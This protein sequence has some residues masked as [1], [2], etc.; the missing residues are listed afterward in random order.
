M[1]SPNRTKHTRQRVC[2]HLNMGSV[3]ML[4]DKNMVNG[5]DVN[6]TVE[7]QTQCQPC[8]IAKQHVKS[9]PQESHTDIAEIGDL[10]V[11][12]LWGP[13][14]THGIGRESYFIPF[15]DGKSRCTMIYFMKHKDEALTKFK[16]YKSFVETQTGYKLKKLRVDG[17]GEKIQKIS[18]GFRNTTGRHHSVF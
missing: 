6:T 18:F 1:E 8:I 15:T 11:T 10:T 3:K 5:M 2:G 13:A 9:F 16:L 4:K 12:D 17:G 14:K 7:P